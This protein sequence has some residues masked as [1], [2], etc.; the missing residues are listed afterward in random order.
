MAFSSNTPP[1]KV[2][3]RTMI[4]P[5]IPMKKS[6]PSSL[7]VHKAKNL[8]WK[9]GLNSACIAKV[10]SSRRRRR[11]SE[12][13]SRRRRRRRVHKHPKTRFAP[14]LRPRAPHNTT[15][16]IMKA[17]NYGGLVSNNE[18]RSEE[19]EEEEEE[20]DMGVNFYASTNSPFH[21]KSR[22]EERASRDYHHIDRDCNSV[23]SQEVNFVEYLQGS[24]RIEEIDPSSSLVEAVPRNYSTQSGVSGS[25]RNHDVCL[26]AMS[27]V[28][29][30]SIANTAHQEC[31]IA[32][33]EDENATLRAR[34]LT[35]E[36][37][38]LALHK[39]VQQIEEDNNNNLLAIKDE[40]STFCKRV[41]QMEES[42]YR[43]LVVGKHETPI[44]L[45]IV[46]EGLEES[47]H[48]NIIMQELDKCNNCNVV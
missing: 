28:H 34:L 40:L 45:N 35:T 15:S 18:D 7:Y 6:S 19:E 39:R 42:N 38:V 11:F 20:E 27:G 26:D 8:S 24:G 13:S 23:T 9:N 32:D 4:H 17:K 2:R 22:E 21:I 36:D 16:F 14:L 33:V 41:R 12:S 5:Q 43:K 10:S 29:A 47:D 44:C 46:V 30:C 31:F 37:K 1:W 48:V 25:S 3:S